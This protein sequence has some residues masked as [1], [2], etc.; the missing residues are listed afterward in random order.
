MKEFIKVM[1]A[2]RD[3]NRVKILKM[4]QHGE[5][6]VCEIQVALGVSQPTVSKHV[7]ILEAAGLLSS[8]KDGLWVHYRL[9]DER[10]SPYA[11]AMLGNMKHWLEQTPEISELTK[12][13]PDIQRQNLCKA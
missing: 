10:S 5:L 7:K 4:L 2:L 1:K 11:A 8:R 9:Q 12:K 13:L 3:P 6:C